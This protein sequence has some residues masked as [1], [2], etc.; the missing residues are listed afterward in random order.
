[1]INPKYGTEAGTNGFDSKISYS[2]SG[3]YSVVDT[4][5]YNVEK[6]IDSELDKNYNNLYEKLPTTKYSIYGLSSF[7]LAAGSGCTS[8][9]IDVKINTAS[10][11]AVTLNQASSVSNV[12]F[13]AD[14]FTT[15]TRTLCSPGV[16]FTSLIYDQ[17]TTTAS[18]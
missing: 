17:P 18:T 16:K 11:Y 5:S 7:T 14:I 6:L 2:Y 1:M 10:S 8:F 13:Q 12:I 15:S 3:L 4:A 9:S